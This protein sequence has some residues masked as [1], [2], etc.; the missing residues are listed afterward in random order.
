MELWK[1]KRGIDLWALFPRCKTGTRWSN[2]IVLSQRI[3]R[4]IILQLVIKYKLIL[5]QDG[6]IL[7]LSGARGRS[8]YSNH[9]FR[10]G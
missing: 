9:F 4:E 7:P 5:R 1:G 3:A 8:L 10:P 6:V 2:L